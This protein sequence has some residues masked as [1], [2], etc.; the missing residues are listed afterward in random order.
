MTASRLTPEIGFDNLRPELICGY[1]YRSA[2]DCRG[3]CPAMF[4]IIHEVEQDAKL[5]KLQA[6]NG[7]VLVF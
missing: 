5:K 7:G 2:S 4:R 6:D 1:C 3:Q